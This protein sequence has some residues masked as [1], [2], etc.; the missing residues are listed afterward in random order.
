MRSSAVLI[1]HTHTLSRDSKDVGL[2]AFPL[3]QWYINTVYRDIYIWSTL[4][5]Q[6]DTR[7]NLN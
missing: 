7:K 3:Q 1:W 2:V 6:G 5:L 4:Q